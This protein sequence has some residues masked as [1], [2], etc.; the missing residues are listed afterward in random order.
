MLVTMGMH[1]P[2]F[3]W[4]GAHLKC[5][6][7]EC[8]RKCGCCDEEVTQGAMSAVAAERV[9]FGNPTGMAGSVPGEMELPAQRGAART[10]PP[11]S[12]VGSSTCKRWSV[13]P[14]EVVV[15]R[16]EVG[17]LVS[18]DGEKGTVKFEVAVT[19]GTRTWTDEYTML[20]IHRDIVTLRAPGRMMRSDALALDEATIAGIHRGTAFDSR[21]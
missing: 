8:N 2:G 9:E 16:G 6:D 10:M 7:P 12:N 21:W 17:E 4:G 19:G 1:V 14:G 3:G 15:V 13:R 18:I 11:R 5:K 20:R